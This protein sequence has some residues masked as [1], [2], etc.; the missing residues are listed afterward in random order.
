MEV[1]IQLYFFPL[2]VCCNF[3]LLYNS[4]QS[5]ANQAK[6]NSLIQHFTVILLVVRSLI[7]GDLVLIQTFNT[8]LLLKIILLQSHL[9]K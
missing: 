5:A 6:A 7:V 9:A 8:Y 4:L 3:I 2:L 1:Q